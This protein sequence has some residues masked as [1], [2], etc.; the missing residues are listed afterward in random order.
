M[1]AIRR[2]GKKTNP[3]VRNQI[4]SYFPSHT[5]YL[6][7]FWG[8]G[9]LFEHKPRSKYNFLNDLDSDVHNAF[10][11]ITEKRAELIEY[12][13]LVPYHADTFQYFRRSKPKNDV[14]RCA[15]FLIL[16][17][18]GYMGKTETI[19]ICTNNS[20]SVLLHEIELT[21]KNLT[22]GKN[23]FTNCDFREFFGKISL[24]KPSVLN[25]KRLND[26][27]ISFAYLDPPY[28][29]TTNNYNTPKWSESDVVD[30]MDIMANQGMK[31]AMS[32]FDHPFV[33]AEAEKRGFKIIQL[34]ERQNMKNRRSEIL[35]LNYEPKNKLF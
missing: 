6:E 7:P 9:G 21:Y 32:E 33:V 23:M 16:S 3:K 24:Q 26:I 11:C 5:I 35:I 17:A 10:I 22:S 13:E 31:M 19:R 29:G 30:L 8:G 4:L 15:K 34:G 14:Q 1:G 2:L 18:W 12:M 28:L 20:K 25:P 27:D